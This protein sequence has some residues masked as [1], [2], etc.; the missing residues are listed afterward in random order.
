MAIKLMY[1]HLLVGT[2]SHLAI[3]IKRGWWIFK[4]VEIWNGSIGGGWLKKGATPS[5][6]TCMFLARVA[7]EYWEGYRTSP[8][9]Y[10]R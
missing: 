7:L 6:T 9:T 3:T 4:W 10:N 5:I 8:A 1:R 2:S